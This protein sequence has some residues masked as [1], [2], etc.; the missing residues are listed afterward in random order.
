MTTAS[1]TDPGLV[2][3]ERA[4]VRLML[5][6]AGEMDIETA[7]GGLVEPFEQ[8]VGP[9]LCDCARE[10]LA[11]W[12]RD[13]PPV[14]NKRPSARPPTPQATID[15]IMLC[16]RERG[17]KALNDPAN[18]QRLRHCDADARARLDQWLADF[19]KGN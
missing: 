6:K 5:I 7:I 19:K 9:L 16:V 10:M 17:L 3:L 11:R 8:L 12:E 18:Q 15:A 13:Y 4:A 2:F 14:E 1:S